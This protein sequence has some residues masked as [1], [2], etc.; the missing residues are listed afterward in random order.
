M[1]SRLSQELQEVLVGQRQLA[2]VP[3]WTGDQ[4]PRVKSSSF[5]APVR[6][7]G[8]AVMQRPVFF[9]GYGP[10]SQVIADMEKWPDYGTNIIQIE[11]GPRAILPAEDRTDSDP[12][13]ALLHTLDRAQR[14]GVA[15]CLLISPHYFPDWALAK[16]PHLHKRREGF[17]QYCLHAPEGHDVL[18]RF[19]AALIPTIKDHPAL[20]S[21]CLS[22]E[23]V[24]VEEPC[25][26]ARHWPHSK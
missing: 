1:S 21:I 14:S 3:R 9:N 22:N 19:I 2:G 24:N 25:E 8:G 11:V 12:V 5:V 13:R 26:P 16:W 18:R 23:P 4:R 10:F 6:M 17:L 15:V 7:P 20:H